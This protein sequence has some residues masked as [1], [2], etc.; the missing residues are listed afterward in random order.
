MIGSRL[1]SY[2]IR[3]L[4]AEG[5]RGSL[6]L[7]VHPWLGRRAAIKVLKAGLSGDP[8]LR[9]GFLER[10]RATQALRHRHVVDL[11]DAGTLASGQPYVMMEH[12]EGEPLSDRLQRSP[13][14][15]WPVARRILEQVAAALAAAHRLG[16]V[17]GDLRPGDIFLCSDPSGAGELV[18]VLG[19]DGGAP[20]QG[21]GAGAGVDERTD[22]YAL[23]AIAYHLITG[24]PPVADDA[25]QTP[26]SVREIDP[27]VPS[28]VEALV[29][30]AL[31]KRPDDRFPSMR[32]LLDALAATPGGPGGKA[33]AEGATAEG[34]SA[35]RR[36]RVLLGRLVAAGV[37]LGAALA[38]WPW[39]P[40]ASPPTRVQARPPPPPPAP[41]CPEPEPVPAAA[42]AAA[43]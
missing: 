22:I 23:G 39:R 1:Q 8:S 16:L 18:K 14:I 26:P 33:T 27:K 21:D 13:T 29:G 41:V 36:H 37:G 31:A 40:G 28:A 19:F 30:R 25:R 4:L 15:P 20:G 32:A 2:E 5:R 12:L 42:A 24:A 17:H 9:A 43:R 38:L 3:S 10:V 6:Y 7:A 35:T 34:S 11:F